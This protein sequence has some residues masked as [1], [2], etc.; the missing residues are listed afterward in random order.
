[1]TQ[2]SSALEGEGAEM[3][4]PT[5]T[6]S[7]KPGTGTTKI[8]KRSR[9]KGIAARREGSAKTNILTPKELEAAEALSLAL[10]GQRE[11]RATLDAARRE[12]GRVTT[13]VAA[14][15]F[16]RGN[17]VWG[18]ARKLAGLTAVPTLV[19]LPTKEVRS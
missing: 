16:A 9:S 4:I 17:I 1:M 7:S 5:K 3:S 8:T 18:E 2:Y 13:E 15:S 11:A 12:I 10:I 19:A 14:L 6:V